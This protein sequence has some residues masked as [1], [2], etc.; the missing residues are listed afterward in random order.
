MEELNPE[1]SLREEEDED[2]ILGI[3]LKDK[4]KGFEEQPGNQAPYVDALSP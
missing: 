1:V 4:E 3:C 2:F